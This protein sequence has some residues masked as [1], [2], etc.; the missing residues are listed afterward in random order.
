VSGKRTPV[1]AEPEAVITW[2]TRPPA[3]LEFSVNFGIF[4]GRE[5]S[6]RELE[7]LGEAL[8]PMLEGVTITTEHRYEVGGHSTVALHQVRVEIGHD[9]L[10]ADEG[11][12][13]RLRARLAGTLGEW[14]DDCLTRVSGQELTHPELLA[15]DA[16][17]DRE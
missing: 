11:D 4:A 15:R 2:G 5:A 9:A 13:E 1:S 17:V 3:A 16:V 8:M 6:R 10:P 12:I 7:R 14:L